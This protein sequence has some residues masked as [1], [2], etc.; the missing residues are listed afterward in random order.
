MSYNIDG[1]DERRVEDRTKAVLEVVSRTNPE[2]IFFQG[3][4]DLQNAILLSVLSPKYTIFQGY[5]DG[6]PYYTL[7]AIKEHI[8]VVK[9][10]I[11]KF[12]SRMGRNLLVLEAKW[13]N[14]NLKLINSHLESLWQGTAD[15][16]NQFIKAMDKMREFMADSNAFVLFGGDTN[17]REP[18]ISNVPEGVQDVW[19]TA[20]SNNEHKYTW[21]SKLNFNKK[22]KTVCRSRYD[23]FFV[24][25]P[26]QAMDFYLEG[27]KCIDHGGLFPSDHF[28]IVCKFTDPKL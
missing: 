10:E 5:N 13:N 14:L 6:F 4:T 17:L 24:K 27:T 19:I 3:V 11:V 18:E 2:I 9:H 1:S 7:T 21:D 16:K 22:T 28:A 15:R 20:G 8:K 26:Y 23:R 12:K 25:S